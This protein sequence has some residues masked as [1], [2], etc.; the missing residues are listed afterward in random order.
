MESDRDR[1][2]TRYEQS[3]SATAA[4]PDVVSMW[5][6]LDDLLPTSGAALDLACGT[7]AQSLWLASRG[8][9]VLALDV[10]PRAIALLD[11]A[12][13]TLGFDDRIDAAVHDTDRGLPTGATG[14]ALIICQRYRV[15]DLYPHLVA[16]LASGGVLCLTVLSA[17]GLDGDAG[18]FHA[19]A[20]E[21]TRAFGSMND[22]EI[23][24][25]AEGAGTA[26]IVVR[27]SA[28]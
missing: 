3:R 19:L 5:P 23:V 25:Q 20:G 26:S 21:L 7:G 9:D 11:E 24:R 14:L 15:P 13:A 2:D 6:E 18:P 10:S 1:W 17:V 27:R 8:L 22:V 12:A 16:R 4:P 28:D